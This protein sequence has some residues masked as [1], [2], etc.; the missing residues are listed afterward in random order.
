MTVFQTGRGKWELDWNGAPIMLKAVAAAKIAT[1]EITRA[2]YETAKGD[3]AWDND[4]G[5]TEEALFWK[6]AEVVNPGWFLPDNPPRVRGSWGVEDKPRYKVDA[7]G[8]QGGLDSVSTKDV[9]LFLEFG[10][11]RMAARPW[12][13]PAWDAWKNEYL[14]AFAAAYAAMGGGNWPGITKEFG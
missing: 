9:A 8:R 3:H 11:V 10:T 5:Q 13:Y 4:T 2:M 6:E 12:L 7:Y 14:P 1:D